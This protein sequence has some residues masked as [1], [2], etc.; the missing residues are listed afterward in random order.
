MRNLS[1]FAFA[2]LIAACPG[3]RRTDE[4]RS[5]PAQTSTTTRN[6]QAVPEN[7]TAMNPVT[8]PQTS[9]PSTRV[10]GASTPA[11]EVQLT[12]Y[13]IQM[14]DSL[15]AG[16]QR[17]KIANA[18]KQTH[19]FVIEGAGI[20]Q[21]LASDLSRGDTTELTVN[22]PAGSYTVYCPVDGHRGKGMQRT[23]VVR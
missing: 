1:F 9:M 14:P 6:P 18:G 23:I 15:A 8:P 7:S 19:N 10:G 20:S 4:S 13:E 22:L 5:G 16:P 2:L 11:V 3:D 21:K 17:F 12:E